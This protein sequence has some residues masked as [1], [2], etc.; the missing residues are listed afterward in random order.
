MT[1]LWKVLGLYQGRDIAWGRLGQTGPACWLDLNYLTEAV[2]DHQIRFKQDV[3]FAH[4]CLLPH[5]ALEQ[6]SLDWS[7][8]S[9]L[10]DV[11]LLAY[12]YQAR[13]Q[14]TLFCTG[15]E[16]YVARTDERLQLGT[17]GP[18]KMAWVLHRR[19]VEEGEQL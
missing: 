13:R 18:P 6:V 8:W 5:P 7:R 9:S 4:G 19:R 1:I 10:K 16:L 12:T 3:P 17:F 14:L 11:R 2:P 15:Y